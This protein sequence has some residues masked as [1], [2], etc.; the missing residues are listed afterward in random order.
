MKNKSV[1]LMLGL[2]MAVSVTAQTPAFP[3]AE[4]FGKWATGGRGGQ[5]VEVTNLEDDA[6]GTIEG[7]FR[8]ALKQ[9]PDD[10]LTVVFRVSGVIELE[11]MIRCKRNGLTLAGQTAPGDGIC[12]RGGKCN[13]GGSQ[14]L[15]IRHLRFRIGL[16][17]NADSTTSFIEGGSIGIENASNWIIDHCTF[18]WSGEENM[19]I[20]DNTKTTVQWCLVHEGLYDAGH[21]KGV[22]GYGTQ[23]GGQT[24]TYHHN[25]LAHNMSRAPR[26]NGARSNDTKVLIDYVNNVNY[27]WGG[28]GACYGADMETGNVHQINFVNNYYKP[29]PAYPGTKTSNYVR[30][31]RSS[32]QSNSQIPQWYMSG[33]RMEGS[34]NTSRNTNNYNGLD[35]KAYTD[36]GIA[37]SRL[38]SETPF[39]VSDPVKTESAEDAFQSVLKGVGAFP[40][41]TVDA[42]I[43]EE[44][45]TGTAL[46]RGSVAGVAPG[47]ID[48]PWDVG[49]Y[50]DYE[51]YNTITDADHDGM[52]DAWEAAHGLNPEDASDR[53][54]NL[55]SGYTAL[56]AY[57]CSLCGEE[58]PIEL[59]K[60]FALVVD[61]NGGGDYTTIQAA[62]D[63]APEGSER[64]LIFVRNGDYQEKLFLGTHYTAVNKVVSIIGESVDGVVIT[65]DDYVGKQIDYPGKGSIK[66]GGETC[67]TFTINAAKGFYME[68]VTVRNPNTSAQA[69]ALYQASDG[70]VLKNCKIL[71]NQDTHRTKKGRRF[72]YYQ[73]VFEGGTDFIY[74]GGTCYFYQCE[75]RSNKAGYLTAP[76]D[77][78]YTQRLST[79]KTLYYGFF[80]NDCDITSTGLNAGSCYLGRPWSEESG[81]VFMNCRLGAHI[82]AKGWKEW[83]GHE[84][85]CSFMEYKSMN[86]DGTALAS[87]S[88]RVSWSMQVAPTD[89]YDYMTLKYIYKKVNA[90]SEFN[91]VPEV[92]A[93]AAPQKR[94]T[95]SGGAV[96]WKPIEGA[97]GYILYSQNKILAFVEAPNYYDATAA[98][99]YSVRA[100][101]AN[102]CLS[103]L[104]GSGAPAVTS[105]EM[106]AILSPEV[107]VRVSAEATPAEGGTA[108]ISPE[109]EVYKKN[110]TV[111]LTATP[112]EG[113]RFVGWMGADTT[114]LSEDV[115][116]KYKVGLEDMA[117][118]AV[119]SV[120]NAV[121]PATATT[122]KVWSEDNVLYLDNIENGTE[123]ALFDL[124]GR[125]VNRSRATAPSHTVA[126]LSAG[127]YLMQTTTADTRRQTMKVT[128]KK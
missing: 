29:G 10:P 11:T 4:G 31:T 113:Y 126:G 24:A 82:N 15:I 87:V 13:F 34:A 56:D 77:V 36:I 90:T 7:S 43:V 81:S 21:G 118:R 76:E 48:R 75:I 103:G 93:T 73:C 94:L 6:E 66:A 122:L 3:T 42:R 92:I 63:A 33:N 121:S 80:F 58:I 17:E 55:K 46:Y 39:T 40:R 112:A 68:N 8:W 128:V 101:G 71:G 72:F 124:T 52:D 1:L 79:G 119:F 97:I 27:N 38:I 78:P 69:I 95:V 23:W 61:P 70:Q 114:I 123:I 100:I 28:A 22:R 9:Y 120:I 89:Y 86:A 16:K 88:Q 65:W 32:S 57:L 107:W 59:P 67:P 85:K 25:L 51:T 109:A 127:L 91:P 74:A 102:G 117:F 54:L 45:R 20:Y 30:S 26:F 98:G 84:N 5:V 83:D 64:T 14:N 2:L 108:T 116:Y 50:P 62:L 104:N 47:I 35:A 53:N 19:T 12:I 115:T 111:T 125:C 96:S 49:G 60:P 106:E 44:V 37:K 18:G 105:G 99:N 41:D 110:T